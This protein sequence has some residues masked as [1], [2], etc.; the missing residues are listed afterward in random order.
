[1]VRDYQSALRI[2]K[3]NGLTCIT[4]ELQV[5]YAGAFITKVGSEGRTA[6]NNASAQSRLGLY[7]KIKELTKSFDA[8]S[9]QIAKMIDA[10]AEL[11]SVDLD[12]MRVLQ[13]S[14]T[15][16]QHLKT[17]LSELNAAKMELEA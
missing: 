13:K 6:N 14:E 1:M 2:A 3:D 17:Q 4:S 16:L 5:V 12:A 8:K 10:K 15:R 7:Q 11:A 9:A